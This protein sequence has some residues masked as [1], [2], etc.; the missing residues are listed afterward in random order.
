MEADKELF[1][2]SEQLKGRII[3]VKEKLEQYDYGAA[4]FNEE[5]YNRYKQEFRNIINRLREIRVSKTA[6]DWFI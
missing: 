6:D 5:Q 3:K 4:D 1:I 2:E